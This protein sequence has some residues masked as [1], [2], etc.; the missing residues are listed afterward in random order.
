MREHHALQER[1]VQ[2]SQHAVLG[3]GIGLE[4]YGVQIGKSRCNW[5]VRMVVHCREGACVCFARVGG[6]QTRKAT[7]PST[8]SR[9]AFTLLC[10]RDNPVAMQK[11]CPLC[12]ANNKGIP[13]CCGIGGAWRGRCG[14]EGSSKPHTWSEGLEA[15]APA[16][17]GELS[18]PQTRFKSC[19][20]H[21]ARR[22]LVYRAC[23]VRTTSC[24]AVII[25]TLGGRN[26]RG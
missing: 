12:G 26:L 25:P 13:S 10:V 14:K 15:C 20:I 19:S 1:M 11:V 23:C 24:L 2:P 18:K 9:F 8:L 16:I 5:L 4:G 6:K 17:S 7:A 22:M 3:F 21:D